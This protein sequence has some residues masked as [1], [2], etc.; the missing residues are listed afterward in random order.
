MCGIIGVYNHPE[1]SNLAYLGLYAM[2][3]RGQESAGIISTDGNDFYSHKSMGLVADIFPLEKIESLRGSMAI[4]HVRYST[5]G[6]SLLNNS[7]PFMINYAHGTLAI[8]H[9]GNL[10]NAEE[11]KQ[12]LVIKGSIFQSSM[13]TEV[14]MHLIAGYRE[15]DLVE[16]IAAALKRVSGAYS[17]VFMNQDRL[18]AARDPRGIRPLV[19][20][21]VGE[22]YIIASESCVFDLIEAEFIREIE[23]GEILVIS[24][25][26]LES[27]H[28][29]PAHK[30][31]NCIFEHIYFARPDSVLFGDTVYDVRKKLGRLLAREHPIEADMVVPV[32]DSG[33][34]AAI[35][36]AQELNIPWELA[37]IRNHYVGR[38]FIEPSQSIRHF[39]VKIKLN[40]IKSMF[41][42][43][44]VVV[45]DDSIVRGTTARKIIKMI[46]A[47]GAKEIHVRI[48]SPPTNFP[49]YYGIDTPTRKELIASSHSVDDIRRYITADSLGYIDSKS[50]TRVVNCEHS[51]CD[52]CFTGKYPI[53]FPG[54]E[55]AQPRQP[56]LF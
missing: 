30:P 52:A 5:T 25:D 9:N 35:G 22:S 38:T 6:A 16:G 23:P 4:G 29:F 10:V 15:P 31:A 43:K 34:P 50:L 24:K 19:L 53:T 2:Q 51:F 48:S 49:C 26:G 41:A 46:R 13:D 17:L 42:G 45:V 20:G 56:T 39:G 54:I 27:Y 32:P 8:A 40:A 3:H 36:Y 12:D 21:K 1:A 44:R 33:I 47:A 14:I 55:G 11:I 37:L 28:P 18:I 7:Q